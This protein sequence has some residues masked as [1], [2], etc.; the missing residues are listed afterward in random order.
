MCTQAGGTKDKISILCLKMPRVFKIKISVFQV[1][2]LAKR[3]KDSLP[4][5]CYGFNMA[6]G[7]FH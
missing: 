2:A 6:F 4:E 1:I 3:Q 5:F 7:F